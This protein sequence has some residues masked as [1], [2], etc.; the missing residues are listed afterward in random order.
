MAFNTSSGFIGIT[1]EATLALYGGTIKTTEFG[2]DVAFSEAA[3]STTVMV[4]FIRMR[5]RYAQ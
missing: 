5:L 2:V 1:N 4:D 3:P